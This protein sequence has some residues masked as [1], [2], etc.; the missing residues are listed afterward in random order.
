MA[1]N[2]V[3]LSTI[4]GLDKNAQLIQANINAALTALQAP[5][6]MPYAPGAPANWAAPA[7]ISMQSALDR[8]AALL[9][10][11]HSGPIP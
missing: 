2:Q 3:Q 11:L 8:M 4:P 1:Q 9:A 7:P 6:G 5:G 10:I